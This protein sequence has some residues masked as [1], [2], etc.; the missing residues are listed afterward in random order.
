MQCITDHF[1]DEMVSGAS[2]WYRPQGLAHVKRSLPLPQDDRVRLVFG[3]ETEFLGGKTLAI[4]PSHYDEFGM[5]VI[6][7]NHFHMKG[8]VRPESCDTEE[9]T[10]DLLVTRLEELA[11]LDLPW[12]KVGLA[13]LTADLV[14]REGNPQLVFD[15]VNER[16]FRAAMRTFARLGAGLELNLSTFPPDWQDSPRDRLRLFR[17]A[18]EEGCKFYFGSDAHHPAALSAVPERAQGIA[19]RLGLQE[20]DMFV[21]PM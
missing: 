10:A 14:F 1:W 6:P 13:H 19:E 5:I 7:P 17:F 20:S 15:L 8:F 9:K 21:L 4:H 12:H 2:N 16:R 18:K 3:C 11:L